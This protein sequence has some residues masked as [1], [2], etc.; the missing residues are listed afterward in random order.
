MNQKKLYLETNLR[1][2]FSVTLMAILGV[3]SITPAFPK[4]VESFGIP[5]QKVGL[6]IIYFTLPGII[7]AP[8]LGIFADRYGRKIILVPSLMIFGIAGTL[9]AFAR[10]FN[11]LLILRII[12]G[13]GAASLGFLNITI[14]GDLY[15]GKQRGTAMGYNASVLS[16][17]AATFPVVGGI[18]AIFGWFFPFILPIFAIPI[19]FVLLFLFNH[20]EQKSRVF[21]NDYLSS[22]WL[23]IKNRKV[24]GLFFASIIVFIILY[25]SLLT[26]LPLLISQG[27][28]GSSFV[29]GL[30]MA[31]MSIV[32]AFTSSKLGMLIRR[33]PKEKLLRYS[34]IFY[35]FALLMMPK[36][37]NL[38]LL[39]ISVGIYGIGHGLNIPIIQTMLAELSTNEQRGVIMSLNG[40]VLRIGQ[41]LGPFVMGIV[42]VAM[43]LD[44]TFYMGSFLATIMVIVT[45]IMIR[46]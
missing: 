20:P 4:I 46:K 6:L 22:A 27:F 26:Y 31:T 11:S 35:A 23:I 10:D 5:P 13:M 37:P 38:W 42:F 16:I 40:L 7:I 44:S 9:C 21:F 32:T 8:I 34:F 18:L 2:I 30:I 17:G 28:D 29:I 45:K 3:S 41:T 39:A 1:I 43:D 14:I 36:I 19:G 12:Q 24:I 15:S 25:G 33:Y